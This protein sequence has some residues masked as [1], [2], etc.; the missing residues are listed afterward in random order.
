MAKKSNDSNVD[1]KNQKDKKPKFTTK[2][3]R[4]FQGL[5]AEIK[6]VIW[7]SK[8]EVKETTGVVVVVVVLVMV[9]IFVVDKLMLGILNLMGFNTARPK[10]SE[11]Q[12]QITSIQ[13]ESSETTSTTTTE[14]AETTTTTNP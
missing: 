9:L 2:V 4:F 12:T 10:P 7:P 5:S 6:K 3:K 1:K 13:E 8:K 14:M 11:P